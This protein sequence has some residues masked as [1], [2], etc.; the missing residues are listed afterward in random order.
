MPWTGKPVPA[1]LL[2][3]AE[4]KSAQFF[5]PCNHLRK[6]KINQKLVSNIQENI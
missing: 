4:I 5:D 3:V 1:L 6:I 2:A